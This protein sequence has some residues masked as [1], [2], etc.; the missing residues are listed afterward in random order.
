MA[1]I[2][3]LETLLALASSASDEAAKRLGHAIR[4]T[5]K[6]EQK[7]LLLQQY[8]EDYTARFQIKMAQGVTPM[9]YRNFQAFLDKLDE[10]IAG[11]QHSVNE[12]KNG[13]TKEKASWQTSER[14]RMSFDTLTNR[15][16]K[17]EQRQENKKDQ[18]QNDEHSTRM[19]HY[20]RH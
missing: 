11:Q 10:A 6:A 2:S 4:A 9:G 16:V 20:K 7:L 3:A 13:V 8:R 18:K 15:A 12:A 5:E 14:K 19:A 17:E 1:T